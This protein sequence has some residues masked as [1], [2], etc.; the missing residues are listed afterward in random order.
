MIVNR[1]IIMGRNSTVPVNAFAAAGTD[2]RS[3]YK[4]CREC[5]GFGWTYV[6]DHIDPS[7]KNSK[8]VCPECNGEGVIVKQ[9]QPKQ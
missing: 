4:V 8:I 6:H 9:E 7:A 3:R 2:W 1:M 5:E